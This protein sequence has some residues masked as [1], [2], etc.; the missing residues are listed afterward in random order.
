MLVMVYTYKKQDYN[1]QASNYFLCLYFLLFSLDLGQT[2]VL[3]ITSSSVLERSA[4]YGSQGCINVNIPEIIAL[5]DRFFMSSL[6][7]SF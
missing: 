6:S 7:A 4:R 2:S 3:F 1:I 5:R